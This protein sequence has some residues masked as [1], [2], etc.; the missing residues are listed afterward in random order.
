MTT[1]TASLKLTN[2]FIKGLENHQNNNY[3]IK[4]CNNIYK[5]N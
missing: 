3:Y 5:I 2:K 1:K 4:F